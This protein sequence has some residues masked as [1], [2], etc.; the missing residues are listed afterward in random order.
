[1]YTDLHEFVCVRAHTL[2]VLCVHMGKNSESQGGEGFQVGGVPAAICRV[3]VRVGGACELVGGASHQGT[4]FNKSCRKM[5][6]SGISERRPAEKEMKQ[7]V[8]LCRAQES[9]PPQL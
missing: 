4:E 9:R 8:S 2:Y 6:G 5:S 3:D 7:S 1:M